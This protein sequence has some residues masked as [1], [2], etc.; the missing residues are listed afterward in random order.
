MTAMARPIIAAAMPMTAP[1]IDC[2]PTR[3]GTVALVGKPNAGKSTLFNRLVGR[4]L[5]PVTHKPQ[6]TRRNVRGILTG[7]DFQMI[8]IDT[9]GLYRGGHGVMD[10]V[11]NRNARNALSEV[12]LVALVTPALRWSRGDEAVLGLARES[13]RAVVLVLSKVDLVKE[14]GRLLPV[15]KEFSEQR[16]CARIVPVSALTGEGVARLTAELAESLPEAGFLFPRDC[17]SDRGPGFTACELIRGKVMEVLHQE[18]PYNTHVALRSFEDGPSLLRIAAVLM[19]GKPGQRGI[20]IGAGGARLKQIGT[21]ARLE[22]ER[23]F[24]KRVF[25]KLSVEVRPHW[26]RDPAI[27]REYLG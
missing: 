16:G 25:L 26:Q 11:L 20:V 10:R 18:L 13:G 6:T 3:C 9:P 22:L 17:D 23:V 2:A 4:R 27:L 15:M 12:D 21:L 1:A 24:D 7:D 19:V 14:K 5:S 8:F